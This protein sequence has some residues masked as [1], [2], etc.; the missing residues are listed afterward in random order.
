MAYLQKHSSY[1]R[2]TVGEV[3]TETRTLTWGE[4]Q[5]Y[6]TGI[7]PTIAIDDDGTV[8][9]LHE[10]RQP[11]NDSLYY[12]V[13]TVDTTNKAINWGPPQRYG[14]GTS[15][16]LTFNKEKV[17]VEMHKSPRRD[18][19]QYRVGNLSDRGIITWGAR[20]PYEA[21]FNPY[22]AITGS[23]EVVEVH[24]SGSLRYLY[25]NT[26]EVNTGTR[27]ISWSR[28]DSVRY[29]RGITPAIASAD[30]GSAIVEVHETEHP[31]KNTL[32]YHTG[33]FK[34]E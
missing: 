6:E 29:D 23:K 13:G 18:L 33:I 17:V 20:Q 25:C 34:T 14:E 30:D 4:S 3:D 24:Q 16:S 7:N 22:I 28:K 19:L 21:G 31:F 5:E 2:Y 11:L 10:S 1:S 15:P 12:L 32:W 27:M 26:G 8:I 9:E